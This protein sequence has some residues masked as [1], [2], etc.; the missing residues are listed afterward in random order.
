MKTSQVSALF[1]STGA[2]SVETLKSQG[3][4]KHFNVVFNIINAGEED[5]E[6][7]ESMWPFGTV[8]LR[9]DNSLRAEYIVK[10]EEVDGFCKLVN[11]VKKTNNNLL[12]PTF[13]LQFP[14]T[15]PENIK[16]KLN[17]IIRSNDRVVFGKDQISIILGNCKDVKATKARIERLLNTDPDVVLE[18]ASPDLK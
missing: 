2:D 7:F 12:E 11:K 5:I 16:H 9:K 3:R 15:I 10:P 4:T 18:M 8:E 17:R 6:K 13:I 1:S 14:S